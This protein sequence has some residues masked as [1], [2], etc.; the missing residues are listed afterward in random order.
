[1]CEPSYTR[2]RGS[3]DACDAVFD[4][5]LRKKCWRCANGGSLCLP[6]VVP[7]VAD[8]AHA[9]FRARADGSSGAACRVLEENLAKVG[10]GLVRS[11]YCADTVRRL[12]VLLPPP[13]ARLSAPRLSARRVVLPPRANRLPPHAG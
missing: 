10:T 9:V 8:A 11:S 2:V 5:D 3:H 4:T 13:R 6:V 1:V 12:S 7:S